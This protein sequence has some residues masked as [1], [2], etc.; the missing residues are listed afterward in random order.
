MSSV[1]DREISGDVEVACCERAAR[2]F[3]AMGHPVRL[4]II[5]CAV[6]NGM[7][8]GDLHRCLDRSQPNISQ[9]L[10]VLREAG[11]LVPKRDGNRVCY[12]IAD[13][14]V[15]EMCR[16]AEEMFGLGEP[17]CPEYL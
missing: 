6:G 15:V 17:N 2:A 7:C 4:A 3:K 16:L 9:H 5:R 11:L 10:S 8:V 1:K 12:H 13:E 14:H